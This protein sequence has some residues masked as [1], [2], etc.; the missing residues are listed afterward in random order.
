MEAN[1]G[2]KG[3]LG[4]VFGTLGAGI[5]AMAGVGALSGVGAVIGGSSGYIAGQAIEAPERRR[6]MKINDKI[7]VTIIKK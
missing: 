1:L 3:K 5:G 4:C 6:Q 2:I 7:D